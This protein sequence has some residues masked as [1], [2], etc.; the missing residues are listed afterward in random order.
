MQFGYI[1]KDDVSPH[2]LV[3]SLEHADTDASPLA[4]D[5]QHKKG[6]DKKDH[7]KDDK[8]HHDD[9]KKDHDKDDDKKHVSL[10]FP[11]LSS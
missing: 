7:D 4:S 11:L 10:R 2:L 9:D 1:K 3:A 8:K 6:D 5:S